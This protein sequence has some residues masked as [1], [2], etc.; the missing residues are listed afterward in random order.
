MLNWIDERTFTIDGCRFNIDISTGSQRR[1]SRANDFTLVKSRAYLNHYIALARSNR[2]RHILELGVFQG[3]SLVFLDKLF[4]PEKIIGVEIAKTPIG[5]L[6]QYIERRDGAAKVYYGTSQ[7]DHAALRRIVESDFS[8]E[9]GL[10]VD[11]ASHGYEL[12]KES[13]AALFPRLTPGGIYVIEDWAWSFQQPQQSA[14][15]PWHDR[16]ALVNLL[17]ELIQEVGVNNAVAGIQITR[18][19]AII[20]KSA[21]EKTGKLFAA[22]GLRGRQMAVL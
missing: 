3:G 17:F 8:G 7:G 15:H 10:V 11:D 14:D 4:R 5:A 13:F 19:M 12:T 9:I 21:A 1:L 2:F 20:R 16:P 18:P 22:T 6:D